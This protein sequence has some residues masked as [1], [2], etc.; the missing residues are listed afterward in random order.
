VAKEAVATGA[1]VRAVVA[2]GQ[3]EGGGA[4]LGPAEIFGS[5]YW[6]VYRP[7]FLANHYEQGRVCDRI[8]GG[9]KMFGDNN[10]FMGYALSTFV[11][12]YEAAKLPE[13]LAL[14]HEILDAYLAL[15]V[16]D[17]D[18]LDGYVY[19]SDRGPDYQFNLV[20]RDNEPSGDQYLGTM[21]ALFDVVTSPEPLV[22]DGVDLKDL[23]RQR[24][25]WIGAR[26]KL[27]EY[28]IKNQVG[29]LV[30]RGDDQRWV[31]WSFEQGFANVSGLPKSAF[32]TS[33]DFSGISIGPDL[34]EPIAKQFV[35][36]CFKFSAACVSGQ[37]IDLGIGLQ[38]DVGC[39]EFNVGLGGDAAVISLSSDPASPRWF[40]AWVSRDDLA[41]EGQALYAMYARYK[42]GDADATL[43]D[44]IARFLDA[45]ATPPTGA[46][47]DPN[48]WCR[49]W[50]WAHDFADPNV[51]ASQGNPFAVF[52]GLDYMLP[53]AFASSRH[54]LLE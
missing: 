38:V 20:T 2:R 5:R 53:R 35:D 31:S 17:G 26:L 21:R 48:G 9:V 45:P 11:F 22:H 1:A 49:S 52:S 3:G 46:N 29:Q 40:S 25:I 4:P 39:N 13:S 10:I 34:H 24:A 54:E 28:R 33:W 32:E 14:I 37:S 30:K 44:P 18:P 15:D 16:L 36:G 19:R 41:S 50:R 23:A 7:Y 27:N 47:L 51:C 42:F 8:E 12:E 43:L 6:D